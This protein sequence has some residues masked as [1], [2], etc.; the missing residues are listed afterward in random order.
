MVWDLSEHPDEVAVARGAAC[1]VEVRRGSLHI[2]SG[3]LPGQEQANGKRGQGR[4]TG[5]KH[6]AS[7]GL[8]G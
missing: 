6:L 4:R 8:N 3:R 7:P 2:G 1:S 5:A